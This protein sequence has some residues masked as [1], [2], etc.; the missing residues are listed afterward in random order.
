MSGTTRLPANV[1]TL[2]GGILAA[3]EATGRV[4]WDDCELD[5]WIGADDRWRFPATEAG[6]RQGLI[7][8][9]PVVETVVRVPGGEAHQRVYGAGEPSG[10]VVVE[11]ENRSPA[12]FALALVLHSRFPR[13]RRISVVREVVHL[14]RMPVLALPHAP[15]HWATA[16]SGCSVRETVT[17]GLAPPGPFRPI[18]GRA[19]I[20][21]A[22]L[23]PVTHRTTR[24]A[25][26]LVGRGAPADVDPLALPGF[27][28]V[29][30]SWIA[31]LDRGLRTELPESL[32]WQ[33]DA[34]RAALLLAGHPGSR[35][36]P[37]TVAALEDWGFDRDAEAAW[38]ALGLR[39]QR[40]AARRAPS[41]ADAWARVRAFLGAA[42]GTGALPG[43]PAGFLAAVR[44]VLV[45]EHDDG[46]DLVPGFPPE[47]LGQSIAVHDL[48]LRA[49]RGS[50]ALRWHGARPALL[51]EVPAGV[52]LRAPSLDPQWSAGGGAGEALLAA[53]PPRLLSM[54][55]ASVDGEPVDDP[56][57]FA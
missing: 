43:G 52:R 36:D 9:V 16:K 49:G 6:V 42:S 35:P 4:Q 33:V 11:I 38:R 37:A 18:R 28:A 40:T 44:D 53:P 10:V 29:R 24:R 45:H 23:F 14:G 55:V 21:A 13:T 51:W 32:Q 39:A 17:A 22:F 31:Q 56:G 54:G 50:F 46:V 15:F 12:P 2:D 5:W 30:R 48:P 1:G 27:D 8:A 20:E 34:A 26:V 7:D 19:G 47:W 41:P 3:V 57:S 25:A